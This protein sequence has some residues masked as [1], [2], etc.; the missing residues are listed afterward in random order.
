MSGILI[1][2]PPMRLSA[3]DLIDC[4][5]SII[6]MMKDGVVVLPHDYEFDYIPADDEP[7]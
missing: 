7:E 5:K 2:K 6:K 4:Q 1:V 3:K